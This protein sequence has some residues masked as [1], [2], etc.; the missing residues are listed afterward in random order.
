MSRL[1]QVRPDDRRIVIIRA[2]AEGV[3]IR[4]EIEALKQDRMR[5][6]LSRLTP[7]QQARVLVALGD[8]RGAVA[9]EIG[10]DHLDAHS[11][12]N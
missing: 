5:S 2:S 7:D 12:P 10:T 3:R 1:T 6:I 9:D 11:H 8:L 4:D